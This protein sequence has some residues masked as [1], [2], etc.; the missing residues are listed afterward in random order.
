MKEKLKF[1]KIRDINTGL[2]STG[3][4][5]PKWNKRGKTW[6][7]LGH[8][9]AHL[10]GVRHNNPNTITRTWEVE[11]FVFSQDNKTVISIEELVLQTGLF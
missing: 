5:V 11:E 10:V 4:I 7:N 1:Y 2:Y 6:N 8:V 9:K 3:G